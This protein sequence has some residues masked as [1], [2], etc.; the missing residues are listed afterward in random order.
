MA[1]QGGRAGAFF[2]NLLKIVHHAR[3]SHLSGSQHAQI[4]GRHPLAD[5]KKI[6]ALRT[7]F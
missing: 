4:E 7:K 2:R 5:D 3:N 6:R 1:R